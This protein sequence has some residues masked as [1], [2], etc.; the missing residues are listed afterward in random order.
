MKIIINYQ[1][2]SYILETIQGEHID[3]AYERLWKIIQHHP[4][5]DYM[6]EQLI[7]ISTIWYYKKR[8]NCQYSNNIEKLILLF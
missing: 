8:L 1:S 4:S 3:E 5:N 2:K 7:N 6:Y